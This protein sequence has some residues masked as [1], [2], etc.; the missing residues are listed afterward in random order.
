VSQTFHKLRGSDQSKASIDSS[1][2]P[3]MW[4][5]QA[6]SQADNEAGFQAGYQAGCDVGS[7]A[8]SQVPADHQWTQYPY[9]SHAVM[10]GICP[11]PAA[12]YI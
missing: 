10:T 5:S 6:G 8:G 9:N 11:F 1:T 4:L 12:S 2:L 7:K 3:E